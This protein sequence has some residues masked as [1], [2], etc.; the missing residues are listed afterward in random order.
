[1][2]GHMISGGGGM[3]RGGG[4]HMGPGAMRRFAEQLD[5]E[6]S[7][8]NHDVIK[9]LAFYFRPYWR[10]TSAA[11]TTM[12]IYTGTVV[13]LPLVVSIVIDRY[14]ATG[15]LSGM[16]RI[17]GLFVA[18]AIA[19]F[20]F[21]YIHQRLMAYVGQ[22]VLYTLR[23]ELFVHIQRLSMSFFDRN[24]TGRIMSRVQ[25]DV[26]QLQ[27]VVTIFVSTL[28]Q[29]L[30][31]VGVVWAMIFLNPLLALIT[32]SVIPLLFLF[33]LIWQR[34]ARTT[35]LRVR[36]AASSVNSELQENIA[37]VRVVQSMNRQ[38]QNIQ[39]FQKSNQENLEANLQ[40]SRLSAALLPSVELLTALGLA[41]VVIFGGIMVIEGNILAGGLVAY[42]LY[43]QRFFEPV[44]TLTSEYGS[45]Q[46]AMV[47]GSRIFEILDLNP[48]VAEKPSAARLP[49]VRGEI[50]YDNVSFSYDK[51]E[52]V[53]TDIN[54][55]ILPGQTVAFVG[56]TGAGKTTLVSLLMRLYDVSTG[57]IQ[58]DGIDVRDVTL[59]SLSQQISIVPQEPYLFSG[60]SILDNIRYNRPDI[61]KAAIEQAAEA[62]G[63]DEFIARL[64]NGYDTLLQERGGNL[65]FG[66]R[67]LI[68]FARALAGSPA[69]LILDEATANIDAE[70][71]AKIQ[72]ALSR[73]LTNRT[74][75]IIAHRLSTIRKADNIVVLSEGSVVEQGTHDALLTLGGEYAKLATFGFKN[76]SKARSDS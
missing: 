3:Y 60:N 20:A 55:S 21:S 8:Y 15:D 4:A 74:A 31:L 11:V 57:T 25:N 70:S 45:L 19:Q 62:V 12:F 7:P 6:G 18:V 22:Q 5:E 48:E 52:T 29:V 47:A 1:M 64:D 17:I 50:V 53:L 23:N 28:G 66:Q 75:I 14:I 43:V 56:T 36:N 76:D 63:A 73:L 41:L 67:Q 72:Q 46:R 44:R 61:T 32:L 37:G 13:A 59:R 51:E 10:I 30:S 71:E 49:R 34:F 40:A 39:K 38:H 16:N 9:R 35:F 65:S 26:R 58:I 69:I 42:A 68:S 2:R 27:E 24:E 54:I 33:M